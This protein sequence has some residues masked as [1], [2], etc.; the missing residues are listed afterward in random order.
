MPTFDLQCQPLTSDL[1][2]LPLTSTCICT[3]MHIYSHTYTHTHTNTRTYTTSN[4]VYLQSSSSG[5]SQ[6]GGA[7]GRFKELFCSPLMWQEEKLKNRAITTL[8]L[9]LA[10]WALG[11]ALLR[12]RH[13]SRPGLFVRTEGEHRCPAVAAA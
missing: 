8:L 7:T 4:W 10:V 5:G 1:Q 6:P 3:H 13:G 12:R 9:P 2:C 11:R